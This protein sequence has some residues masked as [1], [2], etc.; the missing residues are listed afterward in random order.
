MAIRPTRARQ[1]A[2]GAAEHR[3][4]LVDHGREPELARREH[5]RHRRIAAETDDRRRIEPAQQPARLEE[6][7]RHCGD[8]ARALQRTAA[9]RVRRECARMSMPGT[10]RGER[11]G[12]AVG[13]ERNAAPRRP[14]RSASACAG[15]RCPPVPPAASTNVGPRTRPVAALTVRS[16]RGVAGSGPASCPCP[17]PAPASTTRHRTMNGSVM[18]LVG[19]RCRVEAMLM[20]AC[21]RTGLSSP[22][23]DE[24]DKEIALLQAAARS[25]AAR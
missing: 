24:H 20:I 11:I 17:M 8:P 6:A 22:V 16:R 15:N 2:I 21:S 10:G 19:I 5:C 4:L 7:E 3:V 13:G 25:R 18:P 14:A 1:Q 23:A 9:E 12:A